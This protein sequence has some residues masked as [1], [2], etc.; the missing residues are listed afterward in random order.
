MGVHILL[1]ILILGSWI[2]WKLHLFSW[3]IFEDRKSRR[4]F[5]T[6]ALAGNLVGCLLTIAGDGK[7]YPNGYRLEKTEDGGY[8]KKFL[9]SA[10]GEALGSIYVQ[11]PE[12]ENTETTETTNPG[13]SGE[14][15]SEKEKREQELRAMLA[16]Y[17]EE[18]DDPDYYYLPAEWDGKSLEW[19]TP[20][21]STGSLLAVLSI[22]AAFALLVKKAQEEQEA[23]K[24][25]MEQLVLDYSGLVMKFTLLVQAGMTVRKAFGKIAVDYRKK[26]PDKKRYAYEE[27]VA[28]CREMD[29]GISEAEAYRRFGERCGQ[30]R[31]KTFSVLLIQNLQKGSRH[32]SELL[33]KESMEAW[34]ERKR[35]ARVL[36]EAAATKLLLP[37]MMML[38][39]VMALI[40]IPA[41]LAFYG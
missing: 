25:R 11:V 27:I 21:D 7:S 33:E 32:M 6:V 8:E 5:L 17:N 3:N 18:K 41:F 28:A 1:L 20:K 30:I 39:V 34:D 13:E 9:I 10:D 24:K 23:R 15:L 2:A 26:S 38:A 4:I 19:K 12:K 31:Y 14:E 22:F 37:M 40:M 36:G 35:K 29:S 16:L